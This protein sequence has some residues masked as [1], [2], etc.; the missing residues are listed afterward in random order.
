MR[1]PTHFARLA[2]FADEAV[3]GPGIDE[4]AHFLRD[5]CAL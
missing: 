2:A 4:L 1:T 5:V 3:D